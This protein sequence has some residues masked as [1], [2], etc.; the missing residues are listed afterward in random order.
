M[1]SLMEQKRIFGYET[2]EESIDLREL[3][4]ELLHKWKSILVAVLIGAVLMGCYRYFCVTPI[5]Q[6]DAKL[7]I[8]NTDSV[9]SFSDLQL[10]AALT[11]DYADIILSRTV[12]K[13]V[14][15]KLDLNLN[16]KELADLIMVE[17][18]DSTHIIHIYVT[19]DD[20]TLC[21]NI[22]NTLMEVSID[23]IYQIVGSSE[24]SVIDYAEAEA[25]EEIT[26]GITKYIVLGAI[27]GFLFMCVIQVLRILSDT[28][29]KDEAD[30]EKYMNIPILAV[31]PYD[32]EM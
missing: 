11:E 24:P 32:R 23:Q 13:Q 15:K 10:S 27:A 3:I 22:A 19:C 21:L 25:T 31:V 12:L 14:I 30:I 28:T 16:F 20:P 7:Y 17:N 2:Q 6:S 26:S 4:M 9:I 18:P 29:M 1:E 8:T 5:Y